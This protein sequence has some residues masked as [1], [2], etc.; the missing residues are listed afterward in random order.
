[1]RKLDFGADTVM[2]INTKRTKEK[3]EIGG[4]D[5]RRAGRGEMIGQCGIDIRNY[6]RLPSNRS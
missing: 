3:K 6:L 2:V 4:G 1:M 5:R